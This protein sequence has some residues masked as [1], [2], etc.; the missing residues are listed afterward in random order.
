MYGGNPAMPG[1]L[2][3]H[4][5]VYEQQHYFAAELS[6]LLSQRIILIVPTQRLFFFTLVQALFTKR[7]MNTVVRL[8]FF[9]PHV[10]SLKLLN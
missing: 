4:L 2:C 9:C 1:V 6:Q 10:S 3:C 7:V 5:S 8:S